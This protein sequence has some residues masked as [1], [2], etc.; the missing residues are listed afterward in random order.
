MNDPRA[1]FDDTLVRLQT[2]TARLTERIGESRDVRARLLDAMKANAWPDV[3]SA[4]PRSPAD[5]RDRDQRD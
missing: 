5:D 3:R 2:L 4:T 1:G